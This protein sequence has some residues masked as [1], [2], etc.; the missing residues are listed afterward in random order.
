MP[1]WALAAPSCS[2]PIQ[3]PVAPIGLGVT[4]VGGHVGGIYPDLLRVLASKEG[5][6]LN[7]PVVP[8]A[9][10]EMM[11]ELGLA[12][13]L[14]PARRSTRRDGFGLFVPLIQTRAALV[15]LQGTKAH[16]AG[17]AHLHSL[18][19]LQQQELH[20]AI[21]RGYDYGDAY[22]ALVTELRSQGRLEEVADPVSLARA[23][24]AGIADLAIVTPT[25]VT[26]ALRGG[27]AAL[28]AWLPRVQVTTLDDL[29]WG[30][31]GIYVSNKSS[32]NAADRALL[33]AS[34]LQLAKTGVAWREFQRYFPEETLR[35][36][37]RPR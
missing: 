4:V 10:Q 2:R 32:L 19:D 23:L 6:A 28:K 5:C 31:S 34:L 20:V 8:R 21:V 3:V 22:Q 29:P 11:Y 27:D 1:A 14:L 24:D 17:L 37:V 16:G 18:A 13:V 33:H 30:E 36:T 26:G 7:F 12:D 35:Q 25:I 9:R 15:T